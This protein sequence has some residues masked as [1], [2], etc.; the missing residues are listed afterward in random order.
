MLTRGCPFSCNFCINHIYNRT[1]RDGYHRIRSVE[2]AIKELSRAKI[3]FPRLKVINFW[4]DVFPTDISWLRQFSGEYKKYIGIPFIAYGHAGLITAEALSL[5]KRAGISFM[6]IGLQSG[7]E[8][9]RLKVFG[10]TDRDEKI[11]QADD[12]LHN[13]GIRHAYD[14]MFSEFETETDLEKGLAFLLELKKPFEVHKN[15]LIYYPFYKITRRALRENRIQ[16]DQV[17][18]MTN[19]FKTQLVTKKQVLETPFI[20][21]YYL[22]GKRC[23]PNRLIKYMY[24]RKWHLKY[25][26]LLCEIA[27]NIG[28]VE[29]IARWLRN[30]YMP[31]LISKDGIKYAGHLRRSFK[32]L[33][34]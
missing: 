23:V 29:T 24:R 32:R 30:T 6:D 2:S 19:H 16:V 10:R 13:S 21:Y 17:A 27:W 9:T 11:V 20:A 5:L 14:T 31:R 3:L 25:G 7:S 28:R 22:A 34:C 33:L 12:L 8:R 18:G 1:Y 15:R 26:V 4:D